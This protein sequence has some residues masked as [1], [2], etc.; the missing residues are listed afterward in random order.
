M[1][2]LLVTFQSGLLGLLAVLAALNA[3]GGAIP[4]GAFVLVA[5][6]VTLAAWTLIHNRPGNFNIRPAPKPQGVL[7]TSGPYRWIRHPMYTSVVLG[8]GALAWISGTLVGY[9]AW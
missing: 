9:A 1:G 6:S 4:S 8:A 3:V 7:V 5:A 2:N